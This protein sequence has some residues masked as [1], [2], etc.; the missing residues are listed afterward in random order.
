MYIYIYV[1]PC[2][3]DTR[4]AYQKAGFGGGGLNI[5]IYIYILLVPSLALLLPPPPR[6]KVIP[7]LPCREVRP[8]DPIAPAPRAAPVEPDRCVA[9]LR[10][11][12]HLE[13]DMWVWL[14]IKQEE[15]TTGFGPCVHLPGQPILVPVF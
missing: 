15:Q 8:P 12:P 10:L 6:P 9:S 5:D 13:I 1:V 14:K 7:P 2:L 11:A 4:Q 3:Q